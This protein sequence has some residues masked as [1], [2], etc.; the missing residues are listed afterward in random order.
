MISALGVLTKCYQTNLKHNE[1][2]S[3]FY[4]QSLEET[5]QQ[6][7]SHKLTEDDEIMSFQSR[8]G[9]T[10]MLLV[11]LNFPVQKYGYFNFWF[12][13]KARRKLQ[14]LVF[15]DLEILRN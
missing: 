2:T 10:N 14:G 4:L 13:P 3:K 9:L 6:I 12:V 7:K 1:D 11:F 8:S 5:L 15:G